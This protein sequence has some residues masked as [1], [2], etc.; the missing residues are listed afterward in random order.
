MVVYPH[1]EA[2]LK[3]KN[4]EG[5]GKKK[6]DTYGWLIN[7]SPDQFD[8]SDIG[9]GLQLM[10]SGV[11]YY[12]V[13]DGK[14]KFD[15]LTVQ[16][17]G[18]NKKMLDV[19]EVFKD[20]TLDHEDFAGFERD[21]TLSFEVDRAKN[22]I[23]MYQTNPKKKKEVLVSMHK[24]KT[25]DLYSKNKRVYIS[26]MAFSGQSTSCVVEAKSLEIYEINTAEDLNLRYKDKELTMGTIHQVMFKYKRHVDKDST[27]NVLMNQDQI[28]NKVNMIGSK[29]QLLQ[30]ESQEV[31]DWHHSVD[32]KNM[33]KSLDTDEEYKAGF[34]ELVVKL[35]DLVTKQ[36]QIY[37]NMKAADA[38][39][40]ELWKYEYFV[41]E[42]TKLSDFVDSL[43]KDTKLEEIART[44]EDLDWLM[45]NIDAGVID[46]Y[47]KQA[48]ES[49]LDGLTK[50]NYTF[51]W[52]VLWMG[53]AFLLVGGGMGAW[54]L[55]KLN[56]ADK[57]HRL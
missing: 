40:G 18:L 56:R 17:V 33:T 35:N 20:K 6:K 43:A 32:G 42:I 3:K 57:E 52:N 47:K 49:L 34:R 11:S 10:M 30:K 46:K 24:I 15:K 27:L 1:T 39:F 31:Y 51:F 50:V 53:A 8:Q 19:S 45:H 14:S 54:I 25:P 37:E 55:L 21:L 9:T 36:G 23:S 29:I 13:E 38:S 16:E 22:T 12:F 4:L 5:G 7:F 26:M 48:G 2:I 41:D 44:M 28:K